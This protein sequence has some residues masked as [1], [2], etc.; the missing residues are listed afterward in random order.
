MFYLEATPSR[1][2][3]SSRWPCHSIFQRLASPSPLWAL[4]LALV[5][6][7]QLNKLIWTLIFLCICIFLYIMF[8][9]MICLF[10]LHGY[11]YFIFLIA[12]PR[13]TKHGESVHWHVYII[14]V[15]WLSFL[16][17]YQILHSSLYWSYIVDAALA[18][19]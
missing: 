2:R 11:F 19:D 12:S 7:A 18:V 9:S 14:V 16:Q 3:A 5:K 17:Q 10:F 4:W 6:F 13:F 1:S 8:V 15:P